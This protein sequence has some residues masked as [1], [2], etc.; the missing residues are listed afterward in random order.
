MSRPYSCGCN[1]ANRPSS[2]KSVTIPQRDEPRLEKLSKRLESCRPMGMFRSSKDEFL[3]CYDGT[4]ASCLY[5]KMPTT[6]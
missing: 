1:E 5:G 2:F 3:L 4:F 6:D